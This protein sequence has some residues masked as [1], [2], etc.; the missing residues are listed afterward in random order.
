MSNRQHPENIDQIEPHY[1]EHLDGLEVT[2]P[3]ALF[4]SIKEKL[5]NQEEEKEPVRQPSK[6][7]ILHR[8]ILKVAASLAIIVGVFVV[9]QVTRH[10]KNTTIDHG[11]GTFGSPKGSP[12]DSI[13]LKHKHNE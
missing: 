8:L 6:R 11:N 12:T 7:V 3:P 2:P 10:K 5:E 1:Q 4:N 13:L 9:Y